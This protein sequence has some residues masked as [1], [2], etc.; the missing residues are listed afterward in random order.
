MP[1]RSVVVTYAH[2]G[3][4]NQELQ[5]WKPSQWNC[6]TE[7]LQPFRSTIIAVL[8]FNTVTPYLYYCY[9]KS[10]TRLLY[11]TRPKKLIATVKVPSNK[12]DP[13]IVNFFWH[14]AVSVVAIFATLFVFN[15]GNA[16]LEMRDII[17]FTRRNRSRHHFINSLGMIFVTHLKKVRVHVKTFSCVSRKR[18]KRRK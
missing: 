16:K 9:I 17:S 8:I 12:N 10:F 2:R 4:S 18:D 14:R 5:D 11:L 15:Q 7:R 1:A 13:P 6:L 3:S